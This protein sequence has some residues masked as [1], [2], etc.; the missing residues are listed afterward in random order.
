ML[1]IGL[2][3]DGNVYGLHDD[4]KLCGYKGRDGAAAGRVPPARHGGRSQAVKCR[5]VRGERA[6]FAQ[7]ELRDRER[8]G[9]VLRPHGEC[10]ESA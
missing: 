9:A 1:T 5:R 10:D 3:D 8:A 2:K 4:Y 6:A 7:A